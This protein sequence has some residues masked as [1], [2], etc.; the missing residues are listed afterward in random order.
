MCTLPP[1]PP[2]QSTLL[3]R[4]I[5]RRTRALREEETRT[6]KTERKAE[7][8]MAKFS[9]L[10]ENRRARKGKKRKPKTERESHEGKKNAVKRERDWDKETTDR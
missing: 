10:L 1:I 3:C 2:S 9:K 7:R 6:S 4:G 8:G 5:E